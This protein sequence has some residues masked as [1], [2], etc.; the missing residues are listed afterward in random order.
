M[1][2]MTNRRRRKLSLLRWS[3]LLLVALS[4]LPFLFLC[5]F[6]LVWLYEREQL[7]PFIAG[8]LALSIVGWAA[9]RF[10]QRRPISQQETTV[11]ENVMPIDVEVNPEW[12]DSEKKAF[13]LACRSIHDRTSV[14]LAW[15]DLPQI[16]LE[17]IQQVA[18]EMGGERRQPLDFSAPEALLLIEQTA[19]RY[20]EHLRSKLPFADQISIASIYWVWRKR[21]GISTAW[22][23]TDRGRRLT[24]FATNPTYAIL[25][26]MEQLITGGNAS[27]L[28]EQ[29]LSTLQALLLEEVASASIDLYSGR[30]KFS[31]AELLKIELESAQL[32][33]SRIAKPDDPLRV[34][35]VGQVSSG[36]S[37]LLNNLLDADRAE[38]DVS[39]T[40]AKATTYLTQM[41]NV[42]CAFLDSP[43]IDGTEQNRR[44]LL[45]EMFDSD[46]VIWVV[47]ADRPSRSADVAMFEDYEKWIERNPSRRPPVTVFALTFID[48]LSKDWPFPEHEIPEEI[49]QLFA[50]AVQTVARDFDGKKPIPISNSPPNWNL[51]TLASELEHHVIEALMVQRN[52]KRLTAS[53]KSRSLVENAKRGAG[54]VY[55]SA[56][57]LGSK[58]LKRKRNTE[59][60]T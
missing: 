13:E 36:K 26:E 11:N 42:P 25:K 35:V 54:G 2:T 28:S 15:Q 3:H 6:G 20:R 8:C 21:R 53:R 30:L 60:K 43:G 41:D 14:T 59:A 27:Y 44:V 4:A 40:T 7:I 57:F 47:R 49:Q 32:D 17:I 1:T 52:R 12:G 19:S 22:K 24:R 56:R 37:S 50:R 29:M 38:T 45:D 58:W 34:L 5:V 9:K 46:I 23:F 51:D 18:T 55:Y 10:S 31:D 48:R 39:P 16:A 33:K